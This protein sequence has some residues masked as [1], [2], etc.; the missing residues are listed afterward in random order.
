[1]KR[2][3][4][5]IVFLQIIVLGISNICWGLESN[6]DS[7]KRI[8]LA[9]PDDTLKVEKLNKLSYKYVK[10]CKDTA[11]ILSKESLR[12]S[13]EL[14][15]NYGYASSLNQMGLVFKY[16]SQY[17]SAL[18]YYE[19]S[20]QQF[21]K[22]NKLSDAAAVLNRLGNV[23]KRIGDYDKSSESFQKSMMFFNED[24]D[25]IKVGWVLN[26][27]GA[28]YFDMGYY[29]KAIE[30]YLQILEIKINSGNQTDIHI[31]YMNI[32]NAYSSK[33]DN[34]KA[35]MY[36]K[37]ALD[38]F[39]NGNKYDK[40]YLVHNIGTCYEDLGKLNDAK[41]FYI[42]A[43]DLENEIGEKE[44]LIY[45][46]QGL[47]N[48]FI[49][50]GNY[51]KGINYVKES[52]LLSKEIGNIPKQ[53]RLLKNLYSVHEQMGNYKQSM[54]Y[55]KEFIVIE[56]SLY[57][58]KSRLFIVEQ[59]KKY[60]AKTKERQI[61]FLEKERKIQDLELQKKQSESDHKSNQRNFLIL[62]VVLAI[63][64]LVVLTNDIKKRKRRNYLLIKQN[65]KIVDQR[66]EIVKRNEELLDSNKTKDKLFQIIAHDLR[67][68]LVSIDSLTQLVPYWVEEQ[69][70]ESLKKLSKTMELSIS[71]VLSLIDNLLNWALS[72]QGKF[73][74]NPENFEVVDTLKDAIKIYYPIADLKHIDIRFKMSKESLVFADKNMFLTIIRNLLNNSIKFTP[75]NGKIDVGVDYS[76]QFARIWVKDSGIG[77]PDHKKEEVF[78][79]A[80]GQS[81]GTKGE[82]G[83]GLGL[84]F[85]KEFANLNN[86]DVYIDS[87][88][89]KG[90]TITFTL[91]LLNNSVN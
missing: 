14:E 17:D 62:V 84:F 79:L 89:N 9:M 73:P 26:N 47:G 28:L 13:K 80:G 37:L 57:S 52:Y 18:Y 81:K 50:E 60:E 7:L 43:I 38:H 16:Q 19:K 34:T 85:C 70:Y 20:L 58:M 63:V 91:P 25:S 90:T 8:Y 72:Q 35:L 4:Q 77:I 55:L 61:V 39:E 21:E 27:L 40:M 24:G 41:Q 65:K 78:E 66:G 76:H 36:Y 74:Y 56:D 75:E 64:V 31:T 22:L 2:I 68:P 46:L 3:I 54:N 59:E 23:Y 32:G 69:D 71:N 86:G 82:L 6:L 29:D 83:K 33:G 45:S 87:T 30:Y 88:K 42:N 11:Y 48:V 10:E 53:H 44:Q 5:N 15:D 67:S 49:K 51:E 12:I 1:V